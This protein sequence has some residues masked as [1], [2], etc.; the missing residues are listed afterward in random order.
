MSDIE[1]QN[2]PKSP[3]GLVEYFFNKVLLS[4]PAKNILYNLCK[5]ETKNIIFKKSQKYNNIMKIYKM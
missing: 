2:A 4:K 5:N 1:K 3:T